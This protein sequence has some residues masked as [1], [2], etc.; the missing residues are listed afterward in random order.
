MRYPSD[1]LYPGLT[2][3]VIALGSASIAMTILALVLR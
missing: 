3:L 1:G 2:V